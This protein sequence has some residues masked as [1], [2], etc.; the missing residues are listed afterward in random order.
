MDDWISSPFEFRLRPL[1]QLVVPAASILVVLF[2]HHPNQCCKASFAIL[3]PEL[4]VDF[5]PS[6]R[7][8]MKYSS[9]RLYL[10]E[11]S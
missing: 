10:G 9:V 6:F 4:I 5:P 2:P 11:A 1:P 3:H 7:L 8:K